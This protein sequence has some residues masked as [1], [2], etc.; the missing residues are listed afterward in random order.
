MSARAS[1]RARRPVARLTLAVLLAIAV[2]VAVLLLRSERPPAVAA[3]QKG[4]APGRPS[5]APAFTPAAAQAVGDPVAALHQQISGQAVL[6]MFRDWAKYP[7]ESRPLTEGQADVLEPLMV[8]EAPRALVRRSKDGKAEPTGHACLMQASRHTISAGEKQVVTITCTRGTALEENAMEIPIRVTGVELQASDGK[9]SWSVPVEGSF[10]DDGKGEDRVAGDYTYTIG[11][12]PRSGGW[13]DFVMS[14]SVQIPGDASRSSYVLRTAFAVAGEPPA[15]F[16][17]RMSERLVDGSL[18][19][20][21]EVQVKKAGR[22]VIQAN[23]FAE[24]TP[25][26]YATFDRRLEA[27]MRSVDLLFFGKIF[28]DRNAAGSFRVVDLRGHRLNTALSL[29]E[30]SRPPAEVARLLEQAPEVDG[31]EREPLLPWPT[32]Y[33]TQSY[34]LDDFSDA[35]WQ[36]SYK[37]SRIAELERLER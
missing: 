10:R 33:V 32:P 29:E 15:R 11:M 18:V 14:A 37:T 34:A 16:T 9:R 22:Y 5:A 31:P 17:G 23:L 1:T 12:V 36:S 3:G 28:H 30:L 25:I 21:A 4:A 19:V 8:P 7:P 6:S 13:G 35:E 27:G 24:E 26:S 2:P 20:S